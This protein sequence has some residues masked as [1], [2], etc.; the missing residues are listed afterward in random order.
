MPKPARGERTAKNAKKKTK[1]KQMAGAGPFYGATK[2]T[3][4]KKPATKTKSG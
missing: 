1:A 2:K 3:K 4:S